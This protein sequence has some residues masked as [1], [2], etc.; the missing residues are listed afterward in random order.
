M[1]LCGI[2][3]GQKMY[4]ILVF[5]DPQTLKDTLKTKAGMQKM[6]EQEKKCFWMLARTTVFL[7]VLE[8]ILVTLLGPP[9]RRI[10][11]IQYS[12]YVV[13][14]MSLCCLVIFWSD[15]SFVNQS[16]QNLVLNCIA[17]NQL[18]F[19]VGANLTMGLINISIQTLQLSYLLSWVWFTVYGVVPVLVFYFVYGRKLL[20]M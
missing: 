3:F 19:F 9:S 18:Y 1:M 7:W 17:K 10:C 15:R 12:V 8:R 2:G 6:H 20:L 14:L 13:A 11:N 16:N 5:E 4:H